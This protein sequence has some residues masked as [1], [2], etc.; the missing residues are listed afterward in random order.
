MVDDKM[1]GK[2]IIDFSTGDS[3]KGLC[4]NDFWHGDGIY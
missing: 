4:E 2:G 1:H 3:Y